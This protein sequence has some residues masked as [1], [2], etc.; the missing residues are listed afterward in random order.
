MRLDRRT[1]HGG[2]RGVDP[3]D[4]KASIHEREPD[5]R[6]AEYRVEQREGPFLL[7]QGSSASWYRRALSTA[8]AARRARSS[9]GRR[10][11]WLYCRPDSAVTNVIAPSVRSRVG[12]RHDE[13]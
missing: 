6:A 5:R 7:A 11:A 9:A 2:E 8:V 10:S 1:R 13:E 4:L 3:D 12:E